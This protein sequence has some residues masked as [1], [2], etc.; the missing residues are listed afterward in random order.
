MKK[1]CFFVLGM[2]FCGQQVYAKTLNSQ[3]SMD[4]NGLF[5]D[6]KKYKKIRGECH[7]GH[8]YEH[9]VWVAKAM[10]K[11]FVDKSPWV[12]EFNQKDRELLV[13]SAFMHDI[14]KAGDL[15]YKY[16]VKR[17]HPRDGFEYFT[18]K[19]KYKLNGRGKTY[20]FNAWCKH[21]NIHGQDRA[22]LTVLIG[23]HQEFGSM[24]G[25]IKK[26][27]LATVSLLDEFIKTLEK[28]AYESN[29][30][31][32]FPDEHIVR[33][34][35]A[36][37]RADLEGMFPVNH[38]IRQAP[39]LEDHPQTLDAT[40]LASVNLVDTVGYSAGQILLGRFKKY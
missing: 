29:Y 24:L 3:R 5:A 1:I 17:S 34:S 26:D 28:Y 23:M 13:T 2:L 25:K 11:L 7:A 16:L 27:P 9:M 4:Y 40:P 30:N 38:P 6:L 35:M 10:D 39:E 21:M 37:S 14:G 8:L 22:T 33:M 12:H 20:D 18:G 31:K 36:L 15:Q 32:G 19:K